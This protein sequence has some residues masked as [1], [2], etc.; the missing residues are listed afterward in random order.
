MLFWH[1]SGNYNAE[2]GELPPKVVENDVHGALRVSVGITWS[3]GHF[4]ESV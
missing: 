3:T 1:L 4:G 2:E